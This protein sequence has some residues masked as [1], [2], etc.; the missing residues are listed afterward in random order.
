MGNCRES[1]LFAKVMLNGGCV[2]S[3]L[4]SVVRLLTRHEAGQYTMPLSLLSFHPSGD[5]R[6]C[7]TAK[8]VIIFS[9]GFVNIF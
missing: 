9:P 4:S 3:H 7:P 5:S 8:H 6:V 2:E 1:M